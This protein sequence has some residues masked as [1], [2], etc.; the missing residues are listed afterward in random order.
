MVLSYRLLPLDGSLAEEKITSG[1]VGIE[2]SFSG[3]STAYSFV[4]TGG[5]GE[6]RFAIAWARRCEEWRPL[7][8]LLLSA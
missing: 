8:P 2:V 1:H 4:V 5:I 6:H 7:S 3:V